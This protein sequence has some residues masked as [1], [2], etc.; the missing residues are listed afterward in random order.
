MYVYTLSYTHDMNTK[1][2]SKYAL[3]RKHTDT[4]THRHTD[5]Q[6]HRHRD[7]YKHR[8]TNTFIYTQSY[9]HDMNANNN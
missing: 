1:Q 5:T 7:T 9:T 4:Q 2:E 3:A 8:H 6:T